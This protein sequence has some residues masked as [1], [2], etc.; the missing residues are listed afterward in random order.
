MGHCTVYHNVTISRAQAYVSVASVCG[1]SRA[2]LQ[3]T[4]I[5]QSG[6]K[7]QVSISHIAAYKWA[8]SISKP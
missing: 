4:F 6:H 2:T 8:G 5:T 7:Q 3:D 1:V